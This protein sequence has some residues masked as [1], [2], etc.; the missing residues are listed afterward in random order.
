ML[1]RS[2][3]NYLLHLCPDVSIFLKNVF[4]YFILGYAGSSLPHSFF[5]SFSEQ[6]LLQ[7]WGIGFS[8]RWILLLRST[9]SRALRASVVAAPGLCSTGSVV[10]VHRLSCSSACGV[11]PGQGSNPC[12]LPW[13]VD[14]LPLSHQERPQF[15]N[16]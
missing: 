3:A 5:S 8:L 15:L 1:F 7:L 14:S 6:G 10:V 9:A 2:W 4:L 12:L 13:H 11:F 16:L